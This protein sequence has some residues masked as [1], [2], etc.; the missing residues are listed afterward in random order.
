MTVARRPAR[1]PGEATAS[2][3]RRVKE[4]LSR[5]KPP[6]ECCR[7]SE[8]VALVRSSGTFH[9][10]AQGRYALEVDAPDPGVAR[11]VYGGLSALGLSP[12]IRLFSP[13]RAHPRE[14]FVVRVETGELR[15]F[16]RAGALDAHGRPGTGVPRG[17]LGRRCCSGAYLRG[18][19]IAHGSVSEPRRP[20]HMEFRAPDRATASALGALARRA[21]ASARVR[22]H[23][24][25]SAY[26]K[27]S[28]SVGRL[29]AVMGA[30]RGYLEWE[31][32]GVWSGVRA[33][34]NRLAN[35]DQANVR[36]TVTAAAAQRAHIEALERAGTIEALPAALREIAR[37]RVEHPDASLE[38]LGRLCRPPVSKGAVADRLRR[39]ASLAEGAS[40]RHPR[41]HRR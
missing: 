40:R 27:D 41:G 16:V 19:F 8:L 39:I 17:V 34:A 10:L 11:R 32:G 7:R 35:C 31:A 33:Q 9:I 1:R 6:R 24:G 13:G 38:E 4:E 21:G 5:L 36:R 37:E 18:S 25:W 26:T 14:R 3:S 12:E 29:L 28:S 23:R 15:A 30:H 22:V 2:F 20:A